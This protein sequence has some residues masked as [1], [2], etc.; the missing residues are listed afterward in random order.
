MIKN[1]VYIVPLVGLYIFTFGYVYEWGYLSGFSV[2]D[3]V[4][5]HTYAEFLVLSTHAL[6]VALRSQSAIAVILFSSFFIGIFF[7]AINTKVAK[8]WTGRK[9]QGMSESKKFFSSVF[10]ISFSPLCL[11]IIF[12]VPG[13]LGYYEAEALKKSAVKNWQEIELKV[14]PPLKIEGITI[15]KISGNVLFYQKEN[16]ITHV[17]SSADILAIRYRTTS[18]NKKIQLSLKAPG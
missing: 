12:L 1:P 15:R 11:L 5:N 9:R 3:Q 17:I 13:L 2:G 6:T 4:V 10:L 7:S 14:T 16:P 18:H 8:K